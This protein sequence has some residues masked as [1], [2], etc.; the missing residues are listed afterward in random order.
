MQG[1]PEA[2]HG[3][4]F[5]NTPPTNIPPNVFLVADGMPY[6]NCSLSQRAGEFFAHL[7][8]MHFDAIVAGRVIDSIGRSCPSGDFCEPDAWMQVEI[9]ETD[10]VSLRGTFEV[11]A[12]E[13][14]LHHGTIEFKKCCEDTPCPP[15][16]PEE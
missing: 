4:A 11:K 13:S 7:S 6:A 2:W 14:L 16:S 15:Y 12:G 8:E 3:R 9:Q 5:I 10:S 1:D